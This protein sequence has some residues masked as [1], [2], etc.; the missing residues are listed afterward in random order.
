M[1]QK[2]EVYRK[3]KNQVFFK[4]YNLKGR[5]VEISEH[6]KS[7]FECYKAIKKSVKKLE[8]LHI[9]IKEVRHDKE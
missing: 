5:L 4:K 1:R 7:V 2:I 6:Y 9:I 3:E 8:N